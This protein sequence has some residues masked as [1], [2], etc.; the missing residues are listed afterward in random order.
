[1]PEWG[2]AGGAEAWTMQ[3]LA[4]LANEAAR[5]LTARGETVGIVESS[6]GGLV[7]AALIAVPGASAFYLGG[8]VVYTQ[9]SRAGLLDVTPGDLTGIRPSTEPYARLMAAKLK[10]KLGADWVLAETGASG[11]TGNRYGD[12]AGHACFAVLGPTEAAATLE[13]GKSD[14]PGNMRAFARAALEL[15]IAT[16]DRAPAKA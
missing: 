3:D 13:T 1:M 5:R 14:R 7:S 11:P 10:A 15:L 12:A 16:I 8:A 6:I 9:A 4:T 2:L